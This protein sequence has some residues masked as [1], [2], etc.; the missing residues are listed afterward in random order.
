MTTNT[1]FYQEAQQNRRNY[2]DG[3]TPDDNLLLMADDGEDRTLLLRDADETSAVHDE[4]PSDRSRS[5]STHCH[6]PEDKFDYASRNR[7][8]IV[9]IICVIFMII[10]IVGMFFIYERH[11]RNNCTCFYRRCSFKFNSCCN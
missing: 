9:L 8:I 3:D 10:E 6:V 5:P 4:T 2:N 1:N 7:L 11:V